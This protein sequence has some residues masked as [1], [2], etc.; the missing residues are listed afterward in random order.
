MISR[1]SRDAKDGHGP[2][3][4]IGALA[5]ATPLLFPMH[6]FASSIS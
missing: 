6:N 5:L 3:P 1:D 2:W 4:W